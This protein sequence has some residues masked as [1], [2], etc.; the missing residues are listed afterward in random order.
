MP[1]KI[2]TDQLKV[3]H[4]MERLEFV[5]TP[6]FNENYLDAVEDHH[7]RY[8][9]ETEFG[10][11]V[12]HPA[13]LNNYSNST[14]SP[15][16]YLPPGVGG[17]MAA[18]ETEYINPARVGKT[19][20]VSW[21]VVDRYEKRGRQYLVREASIVDEDGTEILRRKTALVFASRQKE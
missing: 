5:V 10:P 4:E 14:R 19:L 8:T 17:I 20:R 2:R 12:V 1:E 6:E 13:L 7:P 15:S 16:F 9:R 3:G 11:P 18:D 21:K